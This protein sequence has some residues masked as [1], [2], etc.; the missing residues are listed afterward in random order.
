MTFKVVKS[1]DLAHDVP[2]QSM[3]LKEKENRSF[4]E[5]SR[6]NTSKAE[7]VSLQ[8]FTYRLGLQKHFHKSLCLPPQIRLP[9]EC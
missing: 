1:S 5:A 7:R 2:S 6:L 9:G 3:V 4:I 8:M